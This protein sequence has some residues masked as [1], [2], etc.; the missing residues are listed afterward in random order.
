M[1]LNS[2]HAQSDYSMRT[3]DFFD[4]GSSDDDF[5]TLDGDHRDADVLGFKRRSTLSSKRRSAPTS[6]PLATQCHSKIAPGEPSAGRPGDDGHQRLTAHGTHEGL[7]VRFADTPGTSYNGSVDELLPD[8][9]HSLAPSLPESAR[10]VPR[11]PLGRNSGTSQH[12]PAG[13]H[14]PLPPNKDQIIAA[15]QIAHEITLQALIRDEVGLD[16]VYGGFAP[17][18][19]GPRSSALP[20]AL[21]AHDPR[22]PLHATFETPETTGGSKRVHVVPPPIDTSGPQKSFPPDI[23]RTPYP[24]TA[25]KIQRRDF[26]K[27]PPS[28]SSAETGCSESILTLSIRRT[29]SYVMRRVTSLTIPASNDYSAIGSRGG[30]KQSQFKTTDFDDAAFF[31]QLRTCYHELTGATRLFS[32][33]SLRRIA[34][35]GPASKAADAGYDWLHQPRSPRVLAYR[36]LTDSFSEEKILQQYLDPS[37]G[38]KRFA[39]VHWARRLAAAP[40]N[41]MPQVD[42]D[43][44]QPVDADLVRRM[45]QPE[46]L[47]FVVGWS[48]KRIALALLLLIFLSIAIAILW[49]FLGKN[50]VSGEAR[51][52]F[53]DAGDRVLPGMV[54][55]I[56]LLLIGLSGIGGWLGVS[57][58][59]M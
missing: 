20:L 38:R 59:I 30:E 41:Q 18:D 23:V 42:D 22:S 57:W 8:E 58:L 54:M 32:A 12:R 21:R 45:E 47:E 9:N 39:F 26:G 17:I 52:G 5:G 40:P 33:R 11:R 27:S 15:H 16:D 49:I 36:G 28:T 34:V 43:S 31:T 46:G 3:A 7:P 19:Q 37:L 4:D 44:D 24:F 13:Q 48:I 6:E 56:C 10:L 55:G 53:R 25:E 51:G 35:S 29:N 50:T 2:L 14:V 1:T